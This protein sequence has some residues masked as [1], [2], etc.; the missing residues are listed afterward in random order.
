MLRLIFIDRL[1]KSVLVNIDTSQ[2][3]V[4]E[5]CKSVL[6]IEKV[7]IVLDFN[8]EVANIK[9]ILVTNSGHFNFYV[10]LQLSIS[11]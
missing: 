7:V 6:F 9:Q 10:H 1:K 3:N 2:R 11:I 5:A 8:E 4:A